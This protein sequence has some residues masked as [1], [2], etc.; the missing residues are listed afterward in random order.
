MRSV[1]CDHY[2]IAPGGSVV[3]REGAINHLKSMGPVIYLR[4]PWMT[5]SHPGL[6]SRGD[7]LG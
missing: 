1:R 5:E 4:V 6:D 3:C 7:R 2:V